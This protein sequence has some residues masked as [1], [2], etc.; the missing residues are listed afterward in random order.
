LGFTINIFENRIKEINIHQ[1]HPEGSVAV[2][3]DEEMFYDIGGIILVSLL[4]KNRFDI[5]K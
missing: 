3:V 2:V 1:C 5:K 4:I